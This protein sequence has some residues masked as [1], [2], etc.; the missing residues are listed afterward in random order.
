MYTVRWKQSALDRLAELWLEAVDRESIN[1]A[2]REIDRV[3]ASNPHGAGESRSE[4]VLVIFCQP[5]GCFFFIDETRDVVE[6]L[7]VWTF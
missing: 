7:R 6:V 1:T 4:K 3:L 5:I 2:V